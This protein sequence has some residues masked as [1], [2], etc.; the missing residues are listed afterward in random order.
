VKEA[1]EVKVV[2]AGMVE[3]AHQEAVEDFKVGLAVRG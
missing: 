1:K 3:D 2:E